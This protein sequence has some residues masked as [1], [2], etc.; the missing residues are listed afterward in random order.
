M[1][2]TCPNKSSKKWKDLV[3]IVGEEKSYVLWNE[4]DGNVPGSFYNKDILLAESSEVT[5]NQSNIK[6]SESNKLSDF[7]K[8]NNFNKI[9]TD[10]Q[11]RGNKTYDFVFKKANS[12]DIKINN[13]IATFKE[14]E[15]LG[16][17]QAAGVLAYYSKSNNSITLGENFPKLYELDKTRILAHESLHGIIT[18]RLNTLD[19]FSKKRFE[20]EISDF[21]NKVKDNKYLKDFPIVDKVL[22]AIEKGGYQEI[23]TYAMT[24]SQFASAL[25]SVIIG[26]KGMD[27]DM[28]FWEKLKELILSVISDDYTLFDELTD[29]LDAHIEI[30]NIKQSGIYSLDY[31]H[32]FTP[33][34]NEI[35]QKDLD[36]KLLNSVTEKPGTIHQQFTLDE[37]THSKVMSD[38]E[39]KMKSFLTSA[40]MNYENTKIIKDSD[41]NIINAVAKADIFNKIVQVIE[42]KRDITTLPEESSHVFVAMIRDTDMY[43]SMMDKIIRF[44]TYNDIKTQYGGIYTSELEFREEAIGKLIAQYIVDEAIKENALNQD[45]FSK[46]LNK[47]WNWIKTKLGLIKSEDLNPFIQ[48]AKQILQGNTKGLTSLDKVIEMSGP[49]LQGLVYYEMSSEDINKRNELIGKFDLEKNNKGF[50]KF[51]IKSYSYINQNTGK[52]IKHTANEY[53]QKYYKQ[54][55]IDAKN[56]YKSTLLA[57]KSMYIHNISANI[58][59]RLDSGDKIENS[60]D[61]RLEVISSV[62]EYLKDNEQINEIYNSPENKKGFFKISEEQ[63][64]EVVNGVKFIYNQIQENSNRIKK[65]T[66]G[67][68]G[69]P[70]IYTRLNLYLEKEDLSNTVDVLVV[71]PNG[72][73]GIYDYKGIQ[74]YEDVTGVKG[75]ADYKIDAY[76]A[77]MTVVKRMLQEEYGVEEFAESRVLPINI[78]L[79]FESKYHNTHPSIGFAKIEMVANKEK[80]YLQQL[81]LANELVTEDKPLSEALEDIIKLKNRLKTESANNPGKEELKTMVDKIDRSIKEIQLNRNAIFVYNEVARLVKQL[82]KKEVEPS[83]SPNY[84]YADFNNYLMYAKIFEEFGQKILDQGGSTLIN[85]KNKEKLATISTM[86]ADI[87]SITLQKI[88]ETL[89]KTQK[90]SITSDL[91]ETSNILGIFKTLQEYDGETYKRMAKLVEVNE[92]NIRREFNRI[93][94]IMEDKEN[95]LRKWAKSK[96]ISIYDAYKSIYDFDKGSLIKKFKKEYFEELHTARKNKDLNWIK[97]NLET[98]ENRKKQYEENLVALEKKLLKDYPEEL[99]EKGKLTEAGEYHERERTKRLNT[100]RSKFDVWDS[101]FS[102]SAWVYEKNPYLQLKDNSDYYSEGWKTLNQQGNEALLDFYNQY[103]E[104]NQYFNEL[105]DGKIDKYFVANIR[106]DTLDRVF[107]VGIGAAKNIFREMKHSLEVVQ[108][109]ISDREID[110]STGKPLP[111]IPLLHY[112]PLWDVA[113]DEEIEGIK[114]ELT[115]EGLDSESIDYE[116]E[117]KKRVNKLEYQKGLKTKSFD[118]TKSLLLFAQSVLTNKFYNDTVD[119]IKSVQHLMHSENINTIK[120]GV[121]G[122]TLRTKD[123]GKLVKIKGVGTND[124]DLFDSYVNMYWYGLET[125]SKDVTFKG[126]PILNDNGNIVSQ[127]KVY[128]GTKTYQMLS[129]WTTMKSL[130][131]NIAAAIGNAVGLY[132]NYKI[133]AAEGIL[134]TNTQS[135]KARDLIIKKDKKSL[136]AINFFE[137]ST[138]NLSLHKANDLSG[139][140]VNKWLSMDRFMTIWSVPDD[141]A[142]ETFLIAIMMNHGFDENGNI[143]RISKLPKGSKS[144]YDLAEIKDDKFHLPGITDNQENFLNFKKKVR[145]ASRMIKGTTSNENKDLIGKNILIKAMMKFRNW[146]P[147]L[148]QARFKNLKY[149]EDLEE[150]DV[151]RYK[152]FMGEFLRSKSVWQI[153]N[154]FKNLAVEVFLDAPIVSRLKGDYSYYKSGNVNKHATKLAFEDF[155][156][157]EENAHLRG[158]VTLEQFEE[159][160]ASKLAGMAKE[161]SIILTLFAIT[162]LAKA[163]IPDDDEEWITRAIAKNAF[164]SSNRGLLELTFWTNPGSIKELI[165]S[166]FADFSTIDGVYKWAQNTLDVTRD[167]GAETLGLGDPK[168][169][170]ILNKAEKDKTPA[171]MR[172]F[173]LMPLGGQ[174]VSFLDIFDQDVK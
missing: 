103:V 167:L 134:F 102:S 136:F 126:K 36:R 95:N 99:D 65:Y 147:G 121:T 45:L 87:R 7:V 46:W 75:L 3:N 129:K 98:T 64:K 151:G 38:V 78:K 52:K 12:L 73:T 115:N 2:I 26:E 15:D 107:E 49:E 133:V 19:E 132:S 47:V 34:E 127:G 71:Y 25:N 93:H 114:K 92:D 146:I 6:F 23:I 96:G 16:V 122:K 104:L 135:I 106:Q 123:N 108:Y 48:S 13:K 149:D 53:E 109:D 62:S 171:M 21:I 42:D 113:T 155:L 33:L 159:F 63:F 162:S 142:D 128:S 56:D 61:I 54:S 154:N 144:L 11:K 55:N 101:K 27:K 160:R 17:S 158:K 174:I 30:N 77:K 72:A 80:E 69:D 24:H 89:N 68:E 20:N 143:Q 157:K 9:E 84:T 166:P 60:E 8:D 86:V 81:P 125:Q 170:A 66:E 74:F 91:V 50:V 85:D 152:V 82:R 140:K 131:F 116:T 119:E 35:V 57:T 40:G 39:K 10:I 83:N 94:K 110:P 124:M 145:K 67:A 76:E 5:S 41:G 138:R 173:G 130:P 165:N 58:M 164:K 1:A 79:N 105:Y 163:M 90:K 112:A 43:N 32:N 18:N 59:D 169:H 137:P 37:V 161:I 70:K 100:F 22:K 31:K 120:T 44:D 28:T 141:K 97:N 168:Y 153:F 51:D 29:L 150:F 118:L 139:S 117:L 88:T 148:A 172:T 111:I 156:S 4:Y 14:I